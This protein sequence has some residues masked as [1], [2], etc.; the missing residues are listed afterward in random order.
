MKPLLIF[1]P[2]SNHFASGKLPI[3]SFSHH[4]TP[5]KS[6]G[7]LTGKF[8]PVSAPKWISSFLPRWKQ[9]SFSGVRI[10]GEQQKKSPPFRGLFI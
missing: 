8:K 6:T 2:Q 9:W 5:C 1:Q 3:I 10:L 7:R 4:Q